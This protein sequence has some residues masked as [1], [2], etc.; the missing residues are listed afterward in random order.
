M[1]IFPSLKSAL[2]EVG[3]KPFIVSFV[4]LF[5]M[6]FLLHSNCLMVIEKL[7]EHFFMSTFFHHSS[8]QAFPI[9]FLLFLKSK[10]KSQKWKNIS[11]YSYQIK[12]LSLYLHI[13]S[14]LNPKPHRLKTKY[15]TVCLEKHLLYE[16]IVTEY[17]LIKKLVNFKW[18]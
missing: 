4:F 7:L 5:L 17:F 1:Y 9:D 16:V 18:H 3:V 12:Y 11:L 13:F 14:C 15:K 10:L 8:M 2:Q 6:T